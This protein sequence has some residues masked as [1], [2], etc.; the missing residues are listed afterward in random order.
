MMAFGRRDVNFLKPPTLAIEYECHK[1]T[2]WTALT[3]S[4]SAMRLRRNT[5]LRPSP[6]KGFQT[7]TSRRLKKNLLVQKVADKMGENWGAGQRGSP[8][9]I[10]L[11]NGFVKSL[12]AGLMEE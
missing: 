1:P 7:K 5:Q 4:L 3:S 8:D 9:H 6:E 12:Y 11:E 10:L 2:G